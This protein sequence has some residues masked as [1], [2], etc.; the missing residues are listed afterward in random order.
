MSY[1]VHVDEGEPPDRDWNLRNSRTNILMNLTSLAIDAGSGPGGD[2]S[3]EACLYKG[4]QDQPWG[5]KNARVREVVKSIKN[6]LA[7]LNWNHMTRRSSGEVTEDRRGS[8]GDGDHTKRMVGGLHGG[9]KKC[10]G[11]TG[12]R[13]CMA[14]TG[15]S[16]EARG[17]DGEGW[18]RASATRFWEPG[19]WIRLLVNS[20]RKD[21]CRCCWAHQGGETLNKQCVRGLWS[22]NKVNVSK[23]VGIIIIIFYFKV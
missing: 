15:N 13:G 12:G 7:E 20:E 9:E 18:E 19:R 4:P 16:G 5:G 14:E 11:G 2:I 1:E 6:P 22:V 21:N 8:G 23:I 10:M 17:Y 3:R